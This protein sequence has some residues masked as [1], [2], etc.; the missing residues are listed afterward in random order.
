[1]AARKTTA[2]VITAEIDPLMSEGKTLADKLK[3]AGSKVTYQHYE[4]ATHEFRRN[5][6]GT[7]RIERPDDHT[8][9]PPPDSD[10]G[11]APWARPA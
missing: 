9:P 2:T 4:G 10:A 7:L 6:P 11:E 1:M 8:A 5:F 3:A